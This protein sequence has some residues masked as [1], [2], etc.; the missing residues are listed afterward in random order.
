MTVRCQLSRIKYNS[1]KCLIP[2]TAVWG[3]RCRLSSSHCA[4]AASAGRGTRRKAPGAP[5]RGVSGAFAGRLG[6]GRSP[7]R[8]EDRAG[9]GPRRTAG[10]G[11][12]NDG[13][14]DDP[15]RRACHLAFPGSK[16][17][18]AL[19][20]NL[21]DAQQRHR[22]VP[23]ATSRQG[24]AVRPHDRSAS[25]RTSGR[26]P[27]CTGRPAGAPAGRRCRSASTGRRRC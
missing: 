20:D 6:D 14:R 10:M 25:M 26:A 17:L 7:C 12:V 15:D 8:R 3:G 9:S 22:V 27:T 16:R 24:S 19:H 13:G 1:I 2:R 21:A 4:S 18:F 5:W 11:I 23:P